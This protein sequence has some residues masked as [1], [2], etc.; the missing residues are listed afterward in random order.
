MPLKGESCS[1]THAPV[2]LNRG[3]THSFWNISAVDGSFNLTQPQ[4]H[5]WVLAEDADF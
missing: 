3:Y 4:K 5:G 1:A 2:T